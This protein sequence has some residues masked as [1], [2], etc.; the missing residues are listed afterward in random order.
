MSKL[1]PAVSE[2][3]VA[4]RLPMR[5]AW[6]W[7]RNLWKRHFWVPLCTMLTVS[8]LIIAFI[9]GGF[10]QNQYYSF[11]MSQMQ[12]KN[13]VIVQEEKDILT[14]N[15]ED[16]IQ[17]SST[18]SLDATLNEYAQKAA[19]ENE[20]DYYHNA[21]NGYLQQIGR[22]SDNI[23]IVALVTDD[24]LMTQYDKAG[25][26]VWTSDTASILTHL[27]HKVVRKTVQQSIPRYALSYEPGYEK[28]NTDN[29]HRLVHI[30]VPV[31]GTDKSA[32]QPVAVLVLSFQMQFLKNFFNQKGFYNDY[33]F[34]VVSDTSG[35]ILY[36]YDYDSV[37]KSIT[38]FAK[39]NNLTIFSRD[40]SKYGIIFN[41]VVNEDSVRNEI[42]DT[43]RNGI[44]L[45]MI[46]LLLL[47][48]CIAL[49]MRR[50]M[51]DL[52][53]VTKGIRSLRHG[54]KEQKI[55]ICGEHEIWQL[56]IQ[57]NKLVDSLEAQRKATQEEYQKRIESMKQADDAK[58]EA[59]ES[60][61]NAHFLCNTL[62]AINYD[63]MKA[64]NE[65]ISLMLRKLSNILRYTFSRQYENVSFIQ[66]VS[67]VEQYLYL[68]RFRMMDVFDYEIDCPHIFDE[69][70]CCKLFLQPFIEN[71]LLHGFEGREKGG[72]IRLKAE[73]ESDYLKVTVSDNGC[74]MDEQTA[75][76]IA[77]VL[78]ENE[79]LNTKV[80]GIGIR[81]VVTRLR[82]F[83]G[84][85]FKVSM[86][87]SSGNG[88]SFSFLLP[89]PES[90]KVEEEYD[91][92]V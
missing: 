3:L 73:A 60:Q 15:L 58:R 80:T 27:Y 56:A 88:T 52:S 50:D 38:T 62:N 10:I 91:D 53:R 31:M 76:E 16:Y 57:Y 13:D 78:Q 5:K 32:V 21:L 33:T 4:G 77:K 12:E 35:K 47:S 65:E 85:E 37:G 69:W 72:L 81:N 8:V 54:E 29:Y 49:F 68:Q 87:T 25:F 83:Y 48:A 84:D 43:Y 26:G 55:E 71:S 79:E 46:M 28:M 66:E 7:I 75:S 19:A 44:L 89:I 63:A 14:N 17:L 36:S 6:I 41:I 64:G 34:G 70:P 1:K 20:W 74:G 11:L 51:K 45:Y 23:Q 39:D 24:G 22:Y 90:M 67:W 61:I 42:T 30:A 82:M 9:F 40:K 92:M 18:V 59:L 86:K 2:K